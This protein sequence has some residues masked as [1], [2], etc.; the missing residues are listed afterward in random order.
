VRAS[1]PGWNIRSCRFDRWL[2]RPISPDKRL[3]PAKIERQPDPEHAVGHSRGMTRM[4]GQQ[5]EG[6]LDDKEEDDRTRQITHKHR[7]VSCRMSCIVPVSANQRRF[8]VEFVSAAANA[9]TIRRLGVRFVSD[10][11]IRRLGPAGCEIP[12]A[13]VRPPFTSPDTGVDGSIL[14]LIWT[15]KTDDRRPHRPADV[16]NSPLCLAAQPRASPRSNGG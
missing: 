9:S 7:A 6:P 14:A 5:S 1:L 2:V 11:C 13:H 8:N 10:A 3:L 4:P 12:A 15:G 16:V